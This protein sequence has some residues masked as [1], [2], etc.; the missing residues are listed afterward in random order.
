MTERQYKQ[1]I[2]TRMKRLGNYAAEYAATIERLAKLYVIA[3]QAEEALAASGYAP[4][5]E[6]VNNRGAK[7]VSKNP[8]ITAMTEIYTMV[9][10]HER[11]LG[12][13]PAALK[14]IGEKPIKAKPKSQLAQ[15][16]E[17]LGG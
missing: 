6:H 13:T 17:R 16:L 9:L 4:V 1:R 8:C 7:N 15:A 5:Q 2:T 14:K 10:A 12:L 11:E 3:E